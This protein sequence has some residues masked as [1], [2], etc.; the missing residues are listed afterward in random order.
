MRELTRPEFRTCPRTAGGALQ[1]QRQLKVWSAAEEEPMTPMTPPPRDSR[2][3]QTSVILLDNLGTS[4]GKDDFSTD[5]DL[6]GECRKIR[7]KL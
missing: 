3:V 5:W 7:K 1:T 2:R 4:E 6:Q